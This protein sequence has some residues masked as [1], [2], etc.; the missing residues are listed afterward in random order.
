MTSPPRTERTGSVKRVEALGVFSADL[1]AGFLADVRAGAQMLC[2][3][4][5]FAVPVRV[6]A[7]EHDEV[8]AEHVDDSWQDRLLRLTCRPDVSGCKVFL[9][10]ASPAVLDPVAPFLQV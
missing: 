1:R 10:V 8:V 5:P 7:C 9:R 3:L 2:A 6:V 4:R